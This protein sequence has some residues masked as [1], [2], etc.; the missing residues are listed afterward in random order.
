MSAT[1]PLQHHHGELHARIAAAAER[2]NVPGV[3]LGILLDG[4]QDSVCHGVTSISNPLPVDEA[5]YFQI[6][7]T[8]KTY[9]ATAVMALVERG[10]LDLQAPVRRY[11]PELRLQDE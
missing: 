10:L 9:T 2:H 7:S 4:Q 8:G 11:L 6:G 3:A 5:T 1:D